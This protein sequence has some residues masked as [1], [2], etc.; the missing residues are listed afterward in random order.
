M[1]KSAEETVHRAMAGQ[2]QL[3]M[4]PTIGECNRV[5]GACLGQKPP[6]KKE[7]AAVLRVATV[8]REWATH[9][10]SGMTERMA[11]RSLGPP[12]LTGSAVRAVNGAGQV[13]SRWE[14]SR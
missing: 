1:D 14:H 11:G 3:A 9:N 10:L 12:C 2:R 7:K 6:E 5:P 4:K 13:R 8:G